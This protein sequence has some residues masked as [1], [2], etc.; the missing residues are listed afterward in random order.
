MD[1][2]TKRV[3]SAVGTTVL[4]VVWFALRAQR[5]DREH[6]YDYSYTPTY[7]AYTPSTDYD[8]DAVDR[9]KRTLEELTTQDAAYE[10]AIAAIDPLVVAS[11]P[12]AT[13]C[14]ALDEVVE[15]SPTW[16]LDVS[17]TVLVEDV[18]ETTVMAPF[19]VYVAHADDGLP[20]MSPETIARTHLLLE[21]LTDGSYVSVPRLTTRDLVIEVGVM[22]KPTKGMKKIK[23]APAPG[24]P[25][26]RG[27]IYDHMTKRVLCAGLV[28]LPT[29]K[30]GENATHVDDAQI[31]K[32]V[33]IMPSAL[34]TAPL[35][36]VEA[37]E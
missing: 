35:P 5:C 11:N 37:T 34:K 24:K 2:N 36:D 28:A 1:D 33:D 8:N 10:P 25:I 6:S 22:P 20:A 3:G 12:K 16:K 30:K 14:Q 9:T 29:P 26:A 15:Q 23:G 21:K 31:T 17:E 18:Y 4:L 19:P 27:W 32:L 7:P 13:Q